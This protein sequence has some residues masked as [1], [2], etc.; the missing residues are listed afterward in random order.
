MRIQLSVKGRMSWIIV[1]VTIG[2]PML[3]F[4]VGNWLKLPDRSQYWQVVATL[5]AIGMIVTPILFLQSLVR[6][7]RGRSHSKHEQEKAED[8]PEKKKFSNKLVLTLGLLVIIWVLTKTAWWSSV[9]GYSQDLAGLN[10]SIERQNQLSDQGNESA[11]REIYQDFLLPEARTMSIGEFVNGF[12]EYNKANPYSKVIRHSERVDGDVAHIDRTLMTCN[13]KECT[14]IKETTRSF[15][16]YQ[17]EGGHWYYDPVD[18]YCPRSTNYQMEPEFSRALSLIEQR[19]FA[20]IQNTESKDIF[21]EITH[22]LD[23]SYAKADTEMGG[24]EG[25]FRFV[26]GQSPER[27]AINVSP[28]YK[29]TDDLL[30]AVLLSHEVTHAINYI[31]GL[32]S[33][34][35]ASCFEDEATAFTVEIEFLAR[36]NK[37]EMNSLQTRLNTGESRE[38]FGIVDTLM[39]VGQGKGKDLHEKALNYVMQNPYYQKQCQGR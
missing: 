34:K 21:N 16:R 25:L 12:V 20:N 9:F 28:R 4:F 6:W 39:R 31:V 14:S 23:I 3:A 15:R 8:R 24:A 38:V 10:K 26:P 22:C 18:V 11:G 5:L 1:F 13:D 7:F 32:E 33:G 2:I 36:L 35:P 37:G 29:S 17:Y 19:Y 30:T 27:L